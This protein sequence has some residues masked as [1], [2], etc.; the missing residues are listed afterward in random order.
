MSKQKKGVQERE[1]RR[2]FDAHDYLSSWSSI[3]KTRYNIKYSQLSKTT[4]YSVLAEWLR[5]YSTMCTFKDLTGVTVTGVQAPFAL[6]GDEA[7]LTP[8][9]Y[10]MSETKYNMT[11]PHKLSALSSSFKTHAEDIG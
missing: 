5:M 11:L 10:A 3:S 4:N 9:L 6:L 7:K 8:L 1:A 2:A